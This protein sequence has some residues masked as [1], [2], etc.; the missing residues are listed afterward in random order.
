M[1]QGVTSKASSFDL[2]PLNP[3]LNDIY[4]CRWVNSWHS[5]ELYE[6]QFLERH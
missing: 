6:F 3:I 1:V 4:T 5:I 2:A